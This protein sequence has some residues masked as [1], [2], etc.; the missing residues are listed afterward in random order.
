MK[1]KTVV[2]IT[3][4]LA[5]LSFLFFMFNDHLPP[6][7]PLKIARIHSGLSIPPNAKTIKF[8]EQYSFTGEGYMYLVLKLNDNNLVDIIREIKKEKYK[9]LMYENLMTDKLIDRVTGCGIKLYDKDITEIKIG[10]YRLNA[11]ITNMKDFQITVIDFQ[12]KELTVFVN[13]P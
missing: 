2:N 6:R 10:F 1:N 11:G 9:Q 7:T 13:F 5:I 12:K 4:L 8:K 3:F